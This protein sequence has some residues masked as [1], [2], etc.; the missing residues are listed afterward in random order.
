MSLGDGLVRVE[1]DI[2]GRVA[3]YEYSEVRIDVGGVHTQ[4]SGNPV[5]STTGVQV[6]LPTEMYVQG[7]SVVGLSVEADVGG[8]IGRIA[9]YDYTEVIYNPGEVRAFPVEF[10]EAP[11]SGMEADMMVFADAYTTDPVL[12]AALGE[13]L[14]VGGAVDLLLAMDASMVD[15]LVTGDHIDASMLLAALLSSKIQVSDSHTHARA[16]VLQYVTNILTGAVGRYDGFDFAGFVRSGMDTYGWK[17][18]GLYR[19]AYAEDTGELVQAMIEFAAED[20]DTTNRKAVRGLFLGADTDGALY[21]RLVDDNDCEATYRVIPHGTTHRAN[22]AQR[23]TSRFWR[24]QLEIADATF[25]DLDNVEWKVVT[26]NRRT[27]S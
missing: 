18:A 4:A 21:A 14:Q 16:R 26:T 9:D 6:M 25:A 12:Y 13:T 15:Y 19:L 20:F 5:I 2:A 11:G 10:G 3:D 7:V 27:R 17:P 22:P 1:V 23:P 24:L 8:I